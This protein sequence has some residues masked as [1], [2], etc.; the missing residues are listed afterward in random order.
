[1]RQDAVFDVVIVGGL[2]HVGLPMG[3]VFANNGLNV[4]LYDTSEQKAAEVKQGRM[5]FLEHGAQ[6]ILTAVIGKTLHISS[7]ISAIS[8]A[9]I[10]M[11]AVGTPVDE[12]LN[13]KLRALFEVFSQLKPHLRPEQ[14][15]IIRSTIYP[16]TCRKILKLLSRDGEPWH[17]A[18]CPERIAQGFAIKE[19]P[20]LPQLVAGL[21][22][23][24]VQEASRLFGRVAPKIIPVSIEEAEL[25]KLF[26]NAWR[27]IQ[28][29][30]S[31]QFY[32]IARSFGVEFDQVRKVLI[33]GYGRAATLP[34]AGFAAG[35]CLLKD[36]MQLAAFNN[37]NFLLG[38]A[39]MMIN[40]GLPNVLVEDLR[41]RRDLSQTT[42]GI[43]GMAFKADVDDIR[44]SLSYKLGKILRFHGAKVLYADEFVHDPTFV[45]TEQLLAS[46]HVVVVGV[47]HA[48]YHHLTIPAGVEVIDLWGIVRPS[49]RIHA[50]HHLDE[51]PSPTPGALCHR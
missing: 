20:E 22:E 2:G 3:L 19:L 38:H 18:Y 25:A 11:I 13:P 32:M 48:A 12:Y 29:A 28:F 41:S 37:N 9:R 51:H 46:C 30:V 44:D 36:T 15:I 16:G 50:D 6:P 34:T 4:C 8:Q 49:E 31:N 14:T 39:A 47:P 17:L 27:Y 43:L 23:K 7:V 21:S 24:A 5:P 10:V 26:A 40:E 33:D 1:M 35:P 42:I 45:S